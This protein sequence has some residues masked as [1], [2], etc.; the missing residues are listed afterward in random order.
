M[1][2]KVHTPY[3]IK[4][5]TKC[6]KFMELSHYLKVYPC[7]QDPAHVILF[8]TKQA[9]KV[10]VHQDTL[11]ALKKEIS[12]DHEH[13][14]AP[15]GMVTPGRDQEIREMTGFF[16][17]RIANNQALDFTIVLNL[18]CNFA[19]TYCFE[20][21]V[22]KKA[23]M[24]SETADKLI[25]YIEG[26]LKAS[27]KNLLVDFYGGE[28]LLSLGLMEDMARKLQAVTRNLG[29]TFSFRMI[30]NGSLFTPKAAEKLVFLGL[31]GLKITLDGPPDNHNRFRPFKSGAGSFDILLENIKNTCDLTRIE[32]G[33]NY[34]GSN[35]PRFV[36]LLD[37]L[38]QSGL[39]PERVPGVKFDPIF[40]PA[41]K[42]I[43]GRNP[44]LGCKSVNEPWILEAEKLLRGEILKRGYDTPK[45]TPLCCMIEN[46]DSLVVN[47]DGKFYKCP[48][49]IELEDYCVGSLDTGIS[50][51]RK[52]YGLDVWKN[53]DCLACEYL[54]LCF[55][56]CRHSTYVDTG[57]INGLSC[58]KP[59]LDS[60]LETLVIQDLS[61][62]KP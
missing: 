50:D 9:S 15:L 17:T 34:S 57:K 12:P 37:L 14:L 22:K 49:F 46:P 55:G 51:Y 62:R 6:E 36:E 59:Y 2:R 13:V 31:S 48:C 53:P 11:E 44:D 43:A 56:G 47:V 41:S 58:Q 7:K 61:L 29:K 45:P 30:T 60:A 40:K 20:E 1:L 21:D 16:E 26:Q 10:R 5:V 25:L 33:G 35:Y 32:I 42:T 23:Y 18:D 39:T 24:S 4:T 27:G 38:A 52:Q 28:P 19:C 54:P 8:S 3:P